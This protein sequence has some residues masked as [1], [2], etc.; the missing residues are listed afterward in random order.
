[1]QARGPTR[2]NA[3]PTP[4]IVIASNSDEIDFVDL[5]RK[6]KWQP[7]QG[8]HDNLHPRTQ[9]P[10]SFQGAQDTTTK[11]DKVPNITPSS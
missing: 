8:A 2:E 11:N 1:M 3:A 4:N 10:S 9:P 6:R 5:P 7:E